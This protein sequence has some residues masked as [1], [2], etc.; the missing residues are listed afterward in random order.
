MRLVI[1]S[2]ATASI[3]LTGAVARA[4][5]QDVDKITADFE[6]PMGDKADPKHTPAIDAPA[7]VNA[8]DWF[9]VKINIGDKAQHPSLVEHFVRWIAIEADGVEIERVY[10]HPVMSK[11]EV[12]FVIALPDSRTFDKDGNTTARK[13]RVVTLRAVEMPTHA[14]Q[15]W[16]EK[17]I[18]VKAAPMKAAAPKK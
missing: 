16:S 3:L 5:G 9:P 18:T 6:K 14:S 17:K 8:G 10:L 11:P 15:F 1:A 7:T 12:T 13:D 4:E 2:F